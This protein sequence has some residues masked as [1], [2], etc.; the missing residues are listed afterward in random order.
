MS[1]VV[2]SF[3]SFAQKAGAETT[4]FDAYSKKHFSKITVYAM[5]VLVK[6]KLWKKCYQKHIFMIRIVSAK[7][8]KTNANKIKSTKLMGFLLH[9]NNNLITIFI[10]AHLISG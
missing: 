4:S 8:R 6:I 3:V 1:V 7:I 9:I 2:Y 5:H 10:L